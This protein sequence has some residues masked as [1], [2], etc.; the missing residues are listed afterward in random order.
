ML[1]SSGGFI[2]LALS[3]EA[4]RYPVAII[5]EAR[6]QLAEIM[7]TRSEVAT[8]LIAHDDVAIRFAR[9][10]GFHGDFN[11]KLPVGRGFAIAVGYHLWEH[12]ECA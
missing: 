10:L 5:K 4:L 12:R 1:L 11:K 3:Q 2:W 9:F 7:T 6:R 8:T